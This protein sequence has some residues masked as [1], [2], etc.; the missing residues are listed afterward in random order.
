MDQRI[1]E[2]TR[3]VLATNIETYRARF[4]QLVVAGETDSDRSLYEMLLARACYS[5][6]QFCL[7]N[8]DRGLEKPGL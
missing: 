6:N 1:H 8:P 3:K 2:A 4:L 7:D 5:Y